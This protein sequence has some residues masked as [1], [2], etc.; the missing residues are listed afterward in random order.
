[1]ATEILG[2]RH[3]RSALILYG[4]ETGNS[5]DVAEDLGRVLE[6]IHFVTRVI[7]MDL[8]ELTHILKHTIVVFVIS[9]TGQGEF[10]RNARAFWKSLLRKRLPP[11]C[12]SHVHF[13]VFG[14]GDSS[15]PQFNWSARKLHRRLE[16]LGAKE[17]YPRGEADEQHPEGIDGTF[18]SW[19]LDFRAIILEKYPLSDGV[20]PIPSGVLLP[21][22]FTL[23]FKE[24]A[25]V[26]ASR[27]QQPLA[28]PQASPLQPQNTKI[29]SAS[30]SLVSA[31]VDGTTPQI[32][33]LGISTKMWEPPVEREIVSR[34]YLNEPSAEPTP[35]EDRLP[36]HDLLPDIPYTIKLVENKRITPTEHWQ[37]VR[38]L[39]FQMDETI[40]YTPGDTMTI[41]PKNFPAD[42]EA[43]IDLMDWGDVADIPLEFEARHPDFFLSKTLVSYH[44]PP[45]LTPL[46]NATLRELLTHNLDFTAIPKRHFFDQIAHWT[47]DKMHAER[48]LEF[49]NP[50]YTDEFFDYTTRP[51]RSMLEVLQDF[52]TVRIPW[53][54]AASLFPPI[55]G[56]QFSIS[57]GGPLHNFSKTSL[58]H[59][60]QLL[61]AIVKYKTVLQKVRNGFCSRYIACLPP[62]TEINVRIDRNYAFYD[63]FKNQPKRPA[64]LVGPGT[65]L[66]PCRSLIW[67]R[68][69]LAM[70]GERVGN[71][72]LIFGGRNRT[73][74]FFYR[75]E[76]DHPAIRRIGFGCYAAFSRDQKEKIYVQD[77]IREQKKLIKC[78]MTAHARIYVCGN[79]GNMPKAVREAFLDVLKEMLAE[80]QDGEDQLSA[81]ETLRKWENDRDYIQET[82]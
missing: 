32:D 37:D 13:A 55:R 5:Q 70:K 66:A 60:V 36:P 29:L 57:S 74:D 56:R 61:V 53:N 65:G 11:E 17:I 80:K 49:T 7:E 21:P 18:L 28:G 59:Q 27:L 78:Y 12:L 46:T 3:D 71:I 25:H 45:G 81:E 4:T 15:Y 76:W 52:P 73:K 19:S 23:R 82:W 6:R 58:T 39:T 67:D 9:T 51:R 48:L 41:Y 40:Y 62:N 63:G 69:A 10:P 68:A 24:D 2:Q 20:V 1:M 16:Q 35:L 79:S 47:D 34:E 64:I 8:V 75:Q 22:K 44:H 54:W 14:L 38:Q 50:A 42:V 72:L 26:A 33:D 43:L 31:T 77:V 30:P